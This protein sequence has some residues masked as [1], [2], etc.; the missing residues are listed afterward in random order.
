MKK[1]KSTA[2]LG[3]KKEK[4]EY[5]NLCLQAEYYPFS[6]V[7]DDKTLEFIASDQEQFK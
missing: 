7:I 3:V 6:L 4:E 5:K 2:T 1:S